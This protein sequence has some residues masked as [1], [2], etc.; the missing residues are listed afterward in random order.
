MEVINLNHAQILSSAVNRKPEDIDIVST[1]LNTAPDQKTLS[2]P[3]AIVAI[4]DEGMELQAKEAL[5]SAKTIS[6]V[7]KSDEEYAA[8]S[9]RQ[10]IDER[11]GEAAG[12][13]QDGDTSLKVLHLNGKADQQ[14][15]L[16][17]REQQI[18][19]SINSKNLASALNSFK[20]QVSKSY[21]TITD[22]FDI[23]MQNGKVT[24]VG[25]VDQD[26]RS[27][28]Q[29]LLDDP[30]NGKATALK[31]TI[32]TFNKDGLE[33]INMM[34]YEERIKFGGANDAGH[35]IIHRTNDLT[36]NEFLKDISYSSVANSHGG[37]T[38][39]KHQEVI[40][41]THYGARYVYEQ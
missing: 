36:E 4:S 10:L 25:I 20:N 9:Y 16:L 32:D 24:V 31:S 23:T 38:W 37:T 2:S 18:A 1:S 27:Q 22:N 26:M 34:I 41:S 7:E 3:A 19:N 15:Q 30:S 28:V 8:M 14:A 39:Q 12:G 21:P 33:M 40:G 13:R 11:N 29:S 5:A 6:Y 35:K 17:L